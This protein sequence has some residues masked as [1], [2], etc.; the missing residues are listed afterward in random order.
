MQVGHL[1]FILKPQINE[2]FLSGFIV[3]YP[4][5]RQKNSLDFSFVGLWQ[6]PVVVGITSVAFSVEKGSCFSQVLDVDLSWRMHKVSECERRKVQIYMGLL[7]EFKV[8]ILDEI[9]VDLDVLARANLFGISK[10]GM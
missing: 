8:L 5:D 6:G 1:P 9:T 3:G 2:L 7:K 4:Y 10:K